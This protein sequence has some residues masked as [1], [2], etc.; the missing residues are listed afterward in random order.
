MQ[1]DRDKYLARKERKESE[2]M[3]RL[4]KLSDRTHN[5]HIYT[6][7]DTESGEQGEIL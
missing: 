2:H 4:R 1:T 6:M 3:D 5:P 7:V